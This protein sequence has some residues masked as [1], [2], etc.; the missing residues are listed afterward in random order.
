[1]LRIG[2][3]T[4]IFA[5][6]CFLC[7]L[8]AGP[9]QNPLPG[10]AASMDGNIRRY[11]AFWTRAT[12]AAYTQRLRALHAAALRGDRLAFD[13]ES[14]RLF[15][16]L[17][18]GHTAFSD[19]WQRIQYNNDPGFDAQPIQGKWVVTESS[20]PHLSLGTIISR[21]NGRPTDDFVRD[22]EDESFIGSRSGD[23]DGLAFRFTW[24]FPRTL[25]VSTQDGRTIAIRARHST[26]DPIE[27]LNSSRP[28]LTKTFAHDVGYI[29]IFSFSSPTDERAALA[30]VHRFA[31]SRAIIV[32][33]RGNQGGS[34]P[35]DLIESL[36]NTPAP[37]WKERS[38]I[39][40]PQQFTYAPSQNHYRGRLVVIIN[41]GC[42]SA[43]EDFVMPLKWTKRAVLL[44]ETTGGSTGQ[45]FVRALS[46]G[47]FYQIGATH[48]WFPDGSRFE[49]VGIAPNITAPKTLN[50]V[51]RHRDSVLDAALDAAQRSR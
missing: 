38:T 49:G 50:D 5:I 41:N 11:F 47:M 23:A 9:A 10:I 48:V 19:A 21:I 24:L 8:P 35:T 32:D 36:L 7:F 26:S 27:K 16:G 40:R 45:P 1:M 4:V 2:L 3:A 31:Q 13:R 34:T 39:R 17:L 25:N 44:G 43:C 15:A 30:A 51:V 37:W 6:S 42:R 28:V 12:R 14:G 33:V 18:N 46:N 20:V 29:R 22:I